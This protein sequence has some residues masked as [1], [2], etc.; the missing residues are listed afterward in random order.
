MNSTLHSGGDS[1]RD[2]KTER[3]P[4]SHAQT[5]VQKTRTARRS[6]PDTFWNTEHSP[7]SFI[8]LM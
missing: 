2:G 6:P 7:T 4:T 8:N 5:T 3:T 1:L